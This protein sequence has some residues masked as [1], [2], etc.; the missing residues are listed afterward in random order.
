MTIGSLIHSAVDMFLHNQNQFASGGLFLMAI[1]SVVA[2]FKSLPGKIKTWAIHQFTVS[3]TVNDE[4]EEFVWIRKWL[5]EQPFMRR[6]RHVDV[7]TRY[8]VYDRTILNPAP[9]EHWMLWSK[10]LYTVDISRTEAQ[11]GQRKEQIIL[12]TYGRNK[13]VFLDLIAAVRE[14]NKTK[15]KVP[16]LYVWDGRDWREISPYYPRP[17]DSVILPIAQKERLVNDIKKF[18]SSRDWYVNMGIPYHRGYLFEGPPGTGKSSLITGLSSSFDADVYMLKLSDM[19]DTNLR[20]A[21]CN[22]SSDAFVIMEDID[23]INQA[24]V[25]GSKDSE[26]KVDAGPVSLTGVSLS[27]L[28]NVMDGLL[29]PAGAMFFMTTNRVETLDPALVRPGRVDLQLHIGMASL[30]QKQTLYRRFFSEGD[31]PEK[32]LNQTMTMAELQ[33]KLMED[34]ATSS[35]GVPV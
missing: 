5:A 1:G 10:R 13:K 17:L 32:Y 22:V 8:K 16:E 3:L 35:E 7:A 4:N 34:K 26:E 9:G 23:C 12:T 25:R 14:T 28:L 30:E 33:Q 6:V 24:H 15:I 11:Q 18:K 19:T 27:G 20:E 2:L 21:I 31:C 29:A